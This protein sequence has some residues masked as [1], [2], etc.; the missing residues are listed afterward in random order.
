ME[1]PDCGL[2]CAKILEELY[3]EAHVPPEDVAAI[4]IEPVQGEGGYVVP[5]KGWIDEI[6]SIARRH[7]ILLVDDEVQAGFGRTGKM[8]GIEHSNTVPDILYTAKGIA[9]GMP[10]GAVI[11]DAKL[12]F[13]VQGAHS[14]TFGG[15]LVACAS[16][17]KT[18]ELIERE[19]MLDNANRMGKVLKDRLDEM[20]ETYPIMGDNRGVGL[21][22][23][24]EYV[25]DRRTK[26]FAVKERNEIVKLAYERGLILL[27]AGKSAIRYIPALNIT[28]EELN[29]GLDV[30]ESCIK[31]VS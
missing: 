19:G 14:N 1:F 21:M 10:M 6:A 7:E 26:E 15:N 11:L 13:G 31:Y 30:L 18:I 9:S 25:K 3:F 28:E 4:F 16:A 24:T 8:F 29:S 22:W 17:L 12:D 5:P 27:P 20:A 2:H 23:A